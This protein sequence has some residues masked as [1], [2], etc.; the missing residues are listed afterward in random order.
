MKS[1]VLL[2]IRK[3]MLFLSGKGILL[4]AFT[5]SFILACYNVH[6]DISLLFVLM[7]NKVLYNSIF[8]KTLY[9]YR[10]P[11][12]YLMLILLLH[13]GITSIVD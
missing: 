9:V 7:K 10:L 12:V 13:T 6:S 3:Y 1:I 11:K 8:S 5:P 4:N 2:N